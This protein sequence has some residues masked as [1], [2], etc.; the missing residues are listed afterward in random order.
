MIRRYFKDAGFTGVAE[1]L[2]RCKGLVIMPLLTY[3]LGAV[4]Y[5]V[6]SQVLVLVGILGPFVTLATETGFM[7]HAAGK[8]DEV[9]KQ[10][11]TAWL[12]Y[13]LVNASLVTGSLALLRS[14]AAEVFFDDAK[15]FSP[16][17]LL[18]AATLYLTVILNIARY[19]FLVR[20][21]PR[22][23]TLI[24][25]MQSVFGVVAV[26]VT[27]LR[28][29]GV[30]ELIIYTLV[31]DLLL[32]IPLFLMIAFRDEF[33][34]PDINIIW[35]IIRFSIPLVPA[36]IAVWALNMVDR[37]F[38]VHFATLADIGIYSLAYTIGYT[39]IPILARP[40]WMMYPSLATAAFNEGRM[41]DLQR[42][43]DY[44]AGTVLILTLP[45]TVGLFVLGTPIVSVLSP[46]EF[47]AAAPVIGLVALGYV[48][49]TMASYLEVHMGFLYRQH[50]FTISVIVSVM[51]NILLN[52]LLIPKYGILGAAIATTISFATQFVISYIVS[53]SL[54]IV[55]INYTF[56]IKVIT[57]SI[58]MGA[59][60]EAM[61]YYL[62]TSSFNSYSE[63]ILV[64]IFGIVV[65]S[66]TILGLGVLPPDKLSSLR[67]SIVSIMPGK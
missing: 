14:Y 16:F 39:I 38:L 36:G 21:R 2:I 15:R 25:V 32:V 40:L 56:V 61:R 22:M 66:S 52:Y 51:V 26:V 3:H 48:L 59:V 64:T 43:F 7:R 60:L 37:L 45:A 17:I 6:W 35:P 19:W 46:P 41:D 24:S 65:Y 42:I 47:A 4:N 12:L 8:S 9:Q 20:H 31:G 5:G 27:L 33:G 67:R 58:I 44:S 18:A 13:I 10:Y 29:D 49:M 30:Y 63:I 55:R 11:F 57:A 34:R 1:I 23:Y 62:F 53:L 28:S 50:F 54:K